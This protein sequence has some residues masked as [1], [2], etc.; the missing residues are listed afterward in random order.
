MACSQRYTLCRVL[1]SNVCYRMPPRIAVSHAAGP[2]KSVMCF[3]LGLVNSKWLV[4]L[5]GLFLKTRVSLHRH[6]PLVRVCQG[7]AW[8][9]TTAEKRGKRK[10]TMKTTTIKTFR[11]VCYMCEYKLVS[12]LIAL[13]VPDYDTYYGRFYAGGPQDVRP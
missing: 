13:A 6:S 2:S 12:L 3:T 10:T 4:T 1:Y 8:R 5:Y 9:K 7:R 11:L